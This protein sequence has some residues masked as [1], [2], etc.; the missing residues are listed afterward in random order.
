M[1][2]GDEEIIEVEENEKV[3]VTDKDG[4]Q[5]VVENGSVVKANEALAAKAE[6]HHLLKKCQ[7]QRV[8][9]YYH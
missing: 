2:N 3:I 1:R 9:K 5:Y 8:K 7:Y 4:E 6:N